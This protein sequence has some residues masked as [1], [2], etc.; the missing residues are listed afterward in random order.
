MWDDRA[1]HFG[2]NWRQLTSV[3][4]GGTENPDFPSSFDGTS[5]AANTQNLNFKAPVDGLLRRML[6]RDTDDCLS[7]VFAD[8]FLGLPG[9]QGKAQLSTWV[10]RVAV[11]TARSPA[12]RLKSD[13][14]CTTTSLL[15]RKPS[16]PS[17]V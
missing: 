7:E 16:A 3:M 11:N 5:T 12:D 4:S 8:V 13:M 10:Y 9:F 2:A 14:L 15:G 1:M 6:G 17:I